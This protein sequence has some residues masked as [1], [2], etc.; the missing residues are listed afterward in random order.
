MRD[1]KWERNIVQFLVLWPG[2]LQY[3]H[4]ILLCFSILRAVIDF[5]TMN[6]GVFGAGY[7]IKKQFNFIGG[8]VYGG[9]QKID[10]PR[11]VVFVSKT[12]EIKG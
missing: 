12:D 7:A 8:V 11:E 3:P 5:D 4:L 6:D 2:S 10:A 9:G 1:S